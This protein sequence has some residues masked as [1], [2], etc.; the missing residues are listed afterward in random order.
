MT[1]VREIVAYRDILYAGR[2]PDLS[3]LLHAAAFGVVVLAAGWL[4]F[5]RLK[6]RFAE[7][8]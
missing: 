7:A 1:E 3:T 6:R 8:L 2:I 5:G 4:A